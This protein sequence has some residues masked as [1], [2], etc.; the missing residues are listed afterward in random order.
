[1]FALLQ[2]P[3]TAAQDALA[4]IAKTEQAPVATAARSG[5]RVPTS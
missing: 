4:L 3:T 1:V 2:A 5:L